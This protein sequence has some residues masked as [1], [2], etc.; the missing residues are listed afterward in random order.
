MT[1][2][3]KYQ[4]A[5]WVLF[6]ICAIFFMAS[7]WKNHDTL[8][9]IGSI[10]FLIACIVFLIPIFS[11]PKNEQKWQQVDW[12]IGS[13]P[14]YL[15]TRIWGI[16]DPRDSGLRVARTAVR[17]ADSIRQYATRNMQPA[18]QD[19]LNPYYNLFW[20]WGIT[21]LDYSLLLAFTIPWLSPNRYA[22]LLAPP[23][24]PQYLFHWDRRWRC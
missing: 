7:S 9:F 20:S 23:P 3:T 4:V 18:T 22:P 24:L 8:T 10:I 1:S 11:K 14:I 19:N 12:P 2:E 17:V 5:G 15:G 16:E 6:I 13:F 21:I